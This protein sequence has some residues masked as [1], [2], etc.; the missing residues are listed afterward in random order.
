VDNWD[1]KS[2]LV[3]N[4]RLLLIS[5]VIIIFK[6]FKKSQKSEFRG[7]T[8][9]YP[10]FDH[11]QF[12]EKWTDYRKIMPIYLPNVVTDKI[13]SWLFM[14]I[15]HWSRFV[16]KNDHGQGHLCILNNASIINSTSSVCSMISKI[17]KD[18]KIMVIFM[19][20]NLSG[21][22]LPSHRYCL[23]DASKISKD[24]VQNNQN[25]TTISKFWSKHGS[26]KCSKYRTLFLMVQ[27]TD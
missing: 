8:I 5:A 18:F 2:L 1:T 19:S 10:E 11:G 12:G 7:V 23:T 26:F 22:P 24:L 16:V 20:A 21:N 4:G 14:N 17:F 9:N 25:R 3:P 13:N 27:L 6:N 15:L